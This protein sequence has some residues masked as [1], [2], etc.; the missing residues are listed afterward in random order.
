[1]RERVAVS[2]KRL[3]RAASI[4]GFVAAMSC[5]SAALPAAVP[6]MSGV[7]LATSPRSVFNENRPELTPRAKTA[8]ETFDP[9]R[10]PVIL[11]TFVSVLRFSS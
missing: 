1:M 4:A 7:W 11:L 5:S 2:M 9:R 6:D 8:L 3:W 10:D